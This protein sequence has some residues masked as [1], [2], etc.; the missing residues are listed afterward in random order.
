MRE[1]HARVGRRVEIEDCD[2]GGIALRRRHRAK[3]GGPLLLRR[4]CSRARDRLMEY[5]VL[6]REEI[7]RA[8]PPDRSADSA[9][10]LTAI[11]P[12]NLPARRPGAGGTARR[13]IEEVTRV[14]MTIANEPE[15]R[16]VRLVA[17]ATE[18]GVDLSAR[19]ASEFG[20]RVTGL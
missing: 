15:G 20:G 5:Q 17:S 7:E 11:E 10:E 1:I 6:V 4:H 9:T 16:S 19:T 12:G 14:Q 8:I 13:K 2:P 18:H 3:R